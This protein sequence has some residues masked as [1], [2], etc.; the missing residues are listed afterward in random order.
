MGVTGPGCL[1]GDSDGG[2]E[3]ALE[4]DPT[5]EIDA[6]KFVVACELSDGGWLDI[7]VLSFG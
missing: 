6:E 4:I 1:E 3:E 7:F 2:I 5:G